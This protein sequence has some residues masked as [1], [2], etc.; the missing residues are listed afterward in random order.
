MRLLVLGSGSCE[1]KVERSSTAYFVEAGQTSLVLD[2]GQ[3]AWRRLLD[4]GR[5]VAAVNAVLLSHHH[6]DHLADL[7]PMLFALNFDPLLSAE[8]KITLVADEAVQKVLKGLEQV[9]GS[10]VRPVSHVFSTVWTRPGEE[11]SIGDL[12]IR[13]LRAAH[14]DS[15]LAYRIE[16]GANSLVYL[17]DSAA[18]ESLVEFARGADLLIAHAA[19][20]GDEPSQMHM[21]AREAGELAARAEVKALL[22]SH[23]YRHTDPAEAVQSAGEC[24]DG[25]IVAAEDL[26]EFDIETLASH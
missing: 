7:L 26:M 11:F 1:L 5:S 13:T 10:W 25:K 23:F 19:G 6:L 16:Y 22:L 18:D 12:E 3:G 21:S 14:I 24:F 20:V 15:S 17:G 9:F 2:L 4:S 8:A